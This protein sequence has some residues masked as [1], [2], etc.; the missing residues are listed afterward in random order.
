SSTSSGFDLSMATGLLALAHGGTGQSSW[1]AGRC[2][3]VNSAGSALES[4]AAD[5]GTGGGSAP[6]ASATVSGTVKTDSTVGDP[7]VYLTTTADTLLAGKTATSRN[8]NTTSPLSG[9]GDLSAD[10]TLSCPS[11]EVTGN[12]NAASGYAGLTAGTKLNT[13]QG[14]EVWSVTDLT[15]Y[16]STSGTGAAAIRSTITSPSTNDVL[17]W[18]GTNW[19]NQAPSGGSNHDILSTTHS[20]STAASAVRGDMIAAI[21]ATTRWQRVAHSATTGG[22]WKWNGTDVVASSGA[23]SGTGS[24]GANTWAS[25]LNA[26]AAPTCT[27][28]ASS[29]L[30][31]AS[32]V[33]LY[34]NG[35]KTWGA[36]SDFTWSFDDSGA[37]SPTLAFAAGSATLSA[38]GS[39][40]NLTLTPSGTG[41]V[42]LNN[43]VG[44]GDSAVSANVL[45]E[46]LKS[47][48]NPTA[49]QFG[50]VGTIRGAETSA[51]NS[52]ALVGGQFTAQITAAN[53][54]NWTNSPGQAGAIGQ[55]AMDAGVTGTVSNAQAFLSNATVSAGTLTN[56]YGLHVT[57]ATG[58]G[59]LNNQYGV[60]IEPLAKGAT[61]NYAIY[62][63][64]TQPARFG[65]TVNAV[66]G[67]QVNG[68][69]TSGRYLKGDGTNFVVS[70]GS[71]SG[72]GSCTNQAVTGLNSDAAPTCTTITSA[73]TSGTFTP[74]AEVL[75]VTDLT[76]YSST[77]GNGTQAIL[78]TITTPASN[79]VLTWN[80]SNWINQAPSGGSA[81]NILSATH[82]DST[83]ASVVR[84][85]LITGQGA[86]PT[87]Q[88][89]AKGSASQCLQMDG[90]A[91][92]IVWGSCAGAGG[93]D[94]VSVNGT[95][96]SDADFDD[97]TPAAESGYQNVK[98]QKDAGSPNNISAEVPFATGSLAGTVSTTTQTFAGDK[99]FNG[100][101]LSDAS[102][103]NRSFLQLLMAQ[104][105]VA[106]TRDSHDLLQRGTSYDTGGHNADWKSFV[107][108]TANGGASRWRLQNRLD[109]ASFADKLIVE[110]TGFIGVGTGSNALKGGLNV[111]DGS[112][113]VT[114]GS[115]L[116]D[117][118][119]RAV[120]VFGAGGA[121]YLG[122]D[123]TNSIEYLMGSS[124]SSGGA[125]MGSVTNH[126]VFF[127]IANTDVVEINASGHLLFL[128]DN[129]QDIGA[130]AATRP[131][132]GYFG[133]SVVTP[134]V[135]ASTTLQTNGTTRIDSSGNVNNV[136]L[137]A[138]GTGNNLTTVSK[139]YMIAAGCDN[140]TAAAAWDLPTSGAAGKACLGTGPRF[141]VLTFA[142]AATSSAYTN[143]RLPSDWTGNVDLTLLYTGDTNSAN[144]IVWQP[145]ESCVADGEDLLAASFTTTTSATGAGPTTA[146]QRKSLDFSSMTMTGCAAGETMFLR[147]QRLGADGSD[148]YTGVAQLLAVEMT[149]RRQQ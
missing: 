32:N 2:V 60:Y 109:A 3:R 132:T 137:N 124:S 48:A 22:Y 19:I 9:G 122:R 111:S 75:S 24:C 100:N 14:Q 96:A 147:I 128:S 127:R 18:N 31:D 133:T 56:F 51:S 13:A 141:G 114:S 33:A 25:T 27:Q 89:L 23:A 135:N 88:R 39:N 136:S 34:N 55:F 16:A 87:W 82:S 98:W 97:A 72:V 131:R 37:S 144:N 99:T 85:D 44:V 116:S 36:N 83:T 53:T 12:K 138:E 91:V 8:I 139:I 70:S 35:S 4:A 102:T 71:A 7:V 62:T 69:G 120:R 148:A 92:D 54:Q 15:D 57:D 129:T 29:N 117:S 80:G 145:A 142:D 65:G 149:I 45:V 47:F 108:V 6:I 5:C 107:N 105:G 43:R 126:P 143:F 1:T 118:D 30:S 68:A 101:V 123:I 77:S 38:G 59:T 41:Y 81:H 52:N 74:A 95:A 93:G 20:D 10:R 103:T 84:G 40:Q 125:I 11:C 104:P 79:D 67:F 49:S 17:A 130:S 64:G 42:K 63:A 76:T 119:A 90:S 86:S 58:A 113:P 146:G 134:T 110:S 21:G 73:Y 61:S 78:S 140:A 66:S 28:P 26:D 94:N 106:G 46:G 115:G 50:L 112:A 121:F